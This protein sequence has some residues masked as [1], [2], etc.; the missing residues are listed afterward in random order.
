MKTV[1][2]HSWEGGDAGGVPAPLLHSF[3][4]WHLIPVWKHAGK[5]GRW[6]S[7]AHVHHQ[8]PPSERYTP[9]CKNLVHS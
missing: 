3:K 6:Q 1:Q 9:D 4:K 2:W 5:Q 7:W 8:S